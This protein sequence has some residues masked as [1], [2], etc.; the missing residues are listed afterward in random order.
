ML[1]IFIEQKNKEMNNLG[2]LILCPLSSSFWAFHHS[3]ARFPQSPKMNLI[4]KRNLD[5]FN[6]YNVEPI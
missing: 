5:E 3:F 1:S 6:A 2:H 4:F